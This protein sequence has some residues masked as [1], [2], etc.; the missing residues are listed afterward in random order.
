MKDRAVQLH[1]ALLSRLKLRHLALLESVARH[2]RLNRVADELGLSQPAITQA[3]R[4]IEDIFMARLFERT[5]RGLS[6]T[7]AG[8]AVLAHARTAL[9]DI[10]STARELAAIE[11]GLQG[12]LRIGVIPHAPAKL[13]EAAL[14][15][16]LSQSPRLSVMV[17]EGTTD[18]L[19]A[20]L[21]AREIDCAIGRS[22]YEGGEADILQEP[23]YH[24]APCL[25]VPA[26]S[27]A[28]LVRGPL[29]WQRLAALDWVLP[30]P[31]TPIRRTANA[32]FASAGVPPPLPL[33]E[34]YS[35]KA[36][37]AIMR[38]Q[39]HAI[40]LLAHDVGTELAA[41]GAGA[42][43]PFELHWSLP[44]ISLLLPK[45]PARQRA[46]GALVE[47]VKAAAA[48]IGKSSRASAGRD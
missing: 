40:A 23:L 31:N 35:L 19:V 39:P 10:E 1:H 41:A 16:L 21:R 46:T 43:L 2:R 45:G 18:E 8:E 30:P 38:T 27:R 42:L 5:S 24:Q 14:S 34:T 17:H 48:G 9:A 29:D 13:L 36:I 12:R 25:L 11:S 20:A 37:E 4:E 15:Q 6:P 32:M 44:P 3:L 47:A 28:R 7:P 22:F 33:V 26:A